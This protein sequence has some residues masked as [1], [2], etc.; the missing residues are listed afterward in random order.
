MFPSRSNEP[1]NDCSGSY[2]A[3]DNV[4]MTCFDEVV[5]RCQ[6]DT[7]DGDSYGR[8]L[9]GSLT[10]RSLCQA[11]YA[12]KSQHER[13]I[14]YKN[15]E[16]FD[17]SEIPPPQTYNTPPMKDLQLLCEV[18]HI[19]EWVEGWLEEGYRPNSERR[20]L[21]LQISKSVRSGDSSV[22]V[23]YALIIEPD[24]TENECVRRGVADISDED[25]IAAMG[26]DMRTVTIV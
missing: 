20:V 3:Y 26:W 16:R 18:Y 9:K 21:R 12:W 1:Y 5:L 19:D 6:V 24:G 11:A 8:V 22:K 17:L 14:Y 2:C 23:A 15:G 7:V 13:T 25:G 10:I 4:T